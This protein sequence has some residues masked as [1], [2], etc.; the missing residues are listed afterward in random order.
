MSAR[1]FG[2]AAVDSREGRGKGS[3]IYGKVKG[4][5]RRRDETSE[6][7]GEAYGGTHR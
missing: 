2:D 1:C 4:M 5:A 6:E 3:M 7:E